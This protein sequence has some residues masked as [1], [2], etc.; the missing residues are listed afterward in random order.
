MTWVGSFKSLQTAI[1][2][3][4]FHWCSPGCAHVGAKRDCPDLTAGGLAYEPDRNVSLFP[5]PLY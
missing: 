5:T 1:G 4:P 2:K 3:T